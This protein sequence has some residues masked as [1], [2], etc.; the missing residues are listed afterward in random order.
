L[1]KVNKKTLQ[2]LIVMSFLFVFIVTAYYYIRTDEKK[3]SDNSESE[4]IQE[5]IFKEVDLVN[6]YPFTPKNVL[7]LYIKLSKSLY[8][9]NITDE[10]IDRLS[11]LMLLLFDDELLELNPPAIYK[12]NLRKEIITFREDNLSIKDYEL[13]DNEVEFW[14]KEDKEYASHKVTYTVKEGNKSSTIINTFI[15]RRNVEGKWKILG[16]TRDESSS[17]DSKK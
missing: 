11:D 9:T 13:S 10:Q 6:N 2:T 15:L 7:D 8:D 1:K 4:E 5:D 16:W 14:T 12:Y 3:S 17:K